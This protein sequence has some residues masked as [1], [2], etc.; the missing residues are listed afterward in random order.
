MGSIYPEIPEAYQQGA[1]PVVMQS[2]DIVT[3]VKDGRSFRFAKAGLI[4]SEAILHGVMYL[5]RFPWATRN[6][7]YEFVEIALA[8]AGIDVEPK[9]LTETK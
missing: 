7:V 6:M 5:C 1:K 8:H 2:K 3:V 4:S 9:P